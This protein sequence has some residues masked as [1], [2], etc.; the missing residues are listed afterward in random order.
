METQQALRFPSRCRTLR[1]SC[2]H[3][4]EVAASRRLHFSEVRVT[5]PS[6]RGNAATNDW[7]N[8]GWKA[9]KHVIDHSQ[10]SG[11][12]LLMLIIIA[13]TIGD[14]GAGCFYSITNLGARCR[15]KERRAREIIDALVES[16]EL[17]RERRPGRSSVLR[18]VDFHE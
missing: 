15:M 2:P 12:R 11:T 10:Q 5:I 4:A 1:A 16:G 18:L 3:A 17:T 6:P 7:G 13:E 14:N 9:V 8:M